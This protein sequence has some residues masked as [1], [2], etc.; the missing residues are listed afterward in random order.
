MSLSPAVC[1]RRAWGGRGRSAIVVGCGYVALLDGFGG[2]GGGG[3][4]GL[5]WCE[6]EIS[7][8]MM[9]EGREGARV[10]RERED[11]RM[12]LQ[13]MT[14][15]ELHQNIEGCHEM[16]YDR[17]LRDLQ[18]H[19]SRLRYFLQPLYGFHSTVGGFLSRLSL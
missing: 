4:M 7:D 12:T 13:S 16:Q 15:M 14:R 18:P 6:C 3:L 11:E 5:D 19:T 9:M 2:G 8:L 1:R 17:D 10:G